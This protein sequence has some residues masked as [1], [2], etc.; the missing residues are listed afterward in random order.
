MKK[1]LNNK[2]KILMILIIII[3]LWLIIFSVDAILFVNYK[4]PIFA[5]KIS[6]ETQENY[7][8]YR[9]QEYMGLFYKIKNEYTDTRI[10]SGTLYL[11]GIP[12]RGF[13]ISYAPVGPWD[14]F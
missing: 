5:I 10:I 14:N 11:F 1:I 4:D 2:K 6:N 13:S 12:I 8:G 7:A 3:I 9:Y